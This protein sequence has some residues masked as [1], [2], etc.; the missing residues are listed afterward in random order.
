M[1]RLLYL[2]Y[3]K[4]SDREPI[5]VRT[6]HNSHEDPTAVDVFGP[7]EVLRD[8]ESKAAG[9]NTGETT[10]LSSRSGRN[11]YC[12]ASDGAVDV[13]GESVGYTESALVTDGS[14]VP[15]TATE[16]ATLVAV[17]IDP[18]APITRQGAI[19]R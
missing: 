1:T 11:T 8:D 5:A 19:G 4:R 12:Y 9:T 17:V 3:K 13:G 14:D 2:W 18:D 7:A 10:A 15:V 6:I 16:D